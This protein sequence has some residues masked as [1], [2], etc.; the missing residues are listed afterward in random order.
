MRLV[1]SRKETESRFMP[2]QF[3]KFGVVIPRRKLQS[4]TTEGVTRKTDFSVAF[5]KLFAMELGLYCLWSML[6][7]PLFVERS[8]N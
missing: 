8:I 3:S 4:L 5:V 6:E 7:N 2:V 1:R